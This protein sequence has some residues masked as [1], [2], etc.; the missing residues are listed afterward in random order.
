MI[1]NFQPRL[2]Q[3]A[4]FAT[5]TLKNTL[6]VLP[7]GMG[8]TNIF[9]M[10]ASHRLSQYPDSKV[11]FLG[12]TRPLIDQYFSV[13]NEHFE[14]SPEKM[15]IL[16]GF[17]A[18]EKRA[19]LWSMSTIIFSTPQGLENDL[20]SGRIS[21]DDVSLLGI[22]EAH[23]AVGNYSYVWIADRYHKS[24]RHGRILALTASP[25]SDMQSIR[26]LCSNLHLEAIEAR[27]Y[28]D[29]DVRDYIRE[30][31]FEWVEVELTDEILEI[32]KL[33]ASILKGRIGK[34]AEWGVVKTEKPSKKELLS[35]Q[36]G[37]HGRIAQG[38][39]TPVLWAA[40]SMIAET[41]KAYHALELL[42]T[43]GISPL[44]R[45]FERFSSESQKSRASK[46]LG[47]DPDFRLA[48]QKTGIL[49]DKGAEH[50]K[51]GKLCYI[52]GD[53][54][55]KK[56]DVKLLIFTQYRDSA[57]KIASELNRVEK[58]SARVFVGQ[59]KKGDTG[60]SQKEQ[61]A[62]LDDFRDGKFNAL[63]ATSIGEEGLD[64]P[65]VDLVI[66]Y[67]PIPSGIRHIQ[68][69]GRTGRQ[70]KGR[71]IVLVAKGTMDEA[72]RWVAFHKEKKMNYSIGKLKESMPYEMGVQAGKRQ[73]NEQTLDRFT[74]KTTIYADSREQGS[75]VLKQLSE[76]AEIILQRL[77]SADYVCSSRAGIEVKK[78]GDFVDSI[79]DGRLLT[80][81]KDLRKSF[82]RPVVIIE[83]AEDIFSIR[84]V[85][86]NAIRGMLA[87]IAVSYGIPILS[88]KNG[89]E[90]AALIMAIAKRE[91]EDGKNDFTPHKGKPSSVREQQEYIISSFPTI[92]TGLAKP[93]L[94]E[95]RTVRNIV[96]ASEEELK[97]VE[98]IGDKKAQEIRRVLDS[99]YDG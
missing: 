77:E 35:V 63:C 22:D 87:T 31:E 57:V 78:T 82:E 44:Q 70:E 61:K 45:Y 55:S 66:F 88:S 84:N 65:R 94:R 69:R 81:M 21:L 18:P 38:E 30:I 3:E 36:A 73:V 10:L 76:S 39:K 7:T 75:Q 1:R 27:T 41:I 50:P 93:L 48:I 42:E 2:Y 33:L 71:V 32:R 68:R 16:T 19:E 11:L 25:G 12:P 56:G 49:Y 14:I 34:L 37:L 86:A 6:V 79:I 60:M 28:S 23:R 29:P 20:I 47:N 53:E 96:N 4:I 43:Q 98:L 97:R 52:V 54:I 15:C 58:I 95:F 51:L 8:K 67:E 13:F 46:N 62:M 74:K 89:L 9:L 91:Q 92:G 24:A 85:N 26:E 80:Q 83:G 72:F 40:I 99:E 90:T 17:I 64:I 5:C 59:A